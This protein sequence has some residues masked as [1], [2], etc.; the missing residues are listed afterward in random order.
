L[1]VKTDFNESEIT[2]EGGS[3]A[4]PSRTQRLTEQMHEFVKEV[5]VKPQGSPS[6]QITSPSATCRALLGS[7]RLKRSALDVQSTPQLLL[8]ETVAEQSEALFEE[9]ADE[10][11]NREVQETRRISNYFR[12]EVISS[13]AENSTLE[14]QVLSSLGDRVPSSALF[15]FSATSAPTN[16][17]SKQIPRSVS[18]PLRAAPPRADRQRPLSDG[19][20]DVDIYFV[21]SA[22]RFTLRVPPDLRIGP[23]KASSRKG[24]DWTPAYTQS[25]KS[26]I[27]DMSGIPMA[28]QM[29]FCHR[30]RMG[31][32][33][34]TLR[35][36]NAH[37]GGVEIQV[38][39]SGN[40]PSVSHA[41]T[42]KFQQHQA[43][44]LQQRERARICSQSDPAKHS[45]PKW[46]S[47]VA[48]AVGT[49]FQYASRGVE[50][51]LAKMFD[52]QHDGE[53]PE[54]FVKL[55]GDPFMKFG[56]YHTW[57][58]DVGTMEWDAVRASQTYTQPLQWQS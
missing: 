53:P 21:Q 57:R 28:K 43:A 40:R 24:S 29:L 48:P 56:D 14:K 49:Y 9:D 44:R 33:K 58:P 51:N 55:M 22:D 39:V 26:M 30:C 47:C 32:D 36:Y 31:Q 1:K 2:D 50:G 27:E 52:L 41:C 5:C 23:D 18:A 11:A 8:D 12:K 16:S 20:V 7:G 3:E 10:T 34:H 38:R 54:L 46:Q 19:L 37:H 17:L 15:G 45:M 35:S 13:G 42:K 6:R 4:S 25:L